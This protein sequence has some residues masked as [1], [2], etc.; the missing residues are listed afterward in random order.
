MLEK[1]C[2]DSSGQNPVLRL[3]R[4][5]ERPISEQL[6]GLLGALLF[7]STEM[8]EDIYDEMNHIG[9]PMPEGRYRVVLFALED[10]NVMSLSGRQR[11]NCQINL[12]CAMREHFQTEAGD[13]LDGYL[14]LMLGYLLGILYPGDSPELV[15][16]LCR[17]TVDYA[18]RVLGIRVHVAIDT[19]HEGA[20]QIERSYQ[21]LQ[22]VEYSRSFYADLIDQVYVTPE[23]IIQRITDED[24]RTRFEHTFFQTAT[25]VCGAVRAEN[26][27]AVEDCLREQ[28]RAIAENCVGLPYPNALNLTVNRFITLL[29][30]RLAE[31]DLADWRYLAERDFSRDLV[32]SATLTEYLAVS[33]IIAR[34]LVDHA[35]TRS[36]QRHDRLMHDIRQYVIENATDMNMGLTAVSREFRIKPRELAESF[37]A[38]FGQSINDVIHLARVKRAKELLLTTDDSVQS[39]AEAVGYCSLATMYRAFSNVEG[40][41]P[42][43]FRQRRGS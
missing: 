41:A 18:Q 30:Y 21:S 14:V 38:Y 2:R 9:L 19:P 39:I 23:N 32:S 43:Q 35:K 31:E 20:E 8:G 24:Q 40:V 42:G 6:Y 28:L 33:G 17:E 13:R 25:R 3:G 11:H 34:Q 26:C 1:W 15:E 22:D 4:K 29:Q 10:P 12:Y 5:L 27:A 7:R 36:V 37:R 16:Q